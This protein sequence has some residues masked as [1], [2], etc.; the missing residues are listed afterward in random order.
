M[1]IW[2]VAVFVALLVPSLPVRGQS[3]SVRGKMEKPD[4]YDF[5]Y[6]KT[7]TKKYRHSEATPRLI[8][9][10]DFFC[11]QC[12]KEGRISYKT[13][14]EMVDILEVDKTYPNPLEG[15]TK[16]H[17]GEF[18]MLERPGH[19][20]L[21]RFMNDM[22]LKDPVFIEDPF[23]RIFVDLGSF[24]SKMPPYARREFELSQ[25]A[26][27]FPRVTSKTIS[28]TPHQRA[29]LY[30]FRAHRLLAEFQHLVGYDPKAPYMVYAPPF[31]GMR[32][33]WEVYIFRKQKDASAF[34][35]GFLG[36]KVN[37][38]LC[39]HLLTE[40]AMLTILHGERRRDVDVNNTF[41]HRL[42]YNF[43]TGYRGYAYDL[44]AW[45]A[46]GYAHL[47]ERRER[48]DFNTIIFGEG[49]IPKFRLPSKWKVGV[50][51]A[52]LAKKAPPFQEFAA[53]ESVGRIP[54]KMHPQIWSLVS[55]LVQLDQK[56]MGRLINILKEKK[57]GE[58][59]RNLLRRALAASYGLT[60]AQVDE[61][62]REW[63]KTTYPSI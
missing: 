21:R 33:K 25:L 8:L 61:G 36:Q 45:L 63:V 62:W 40:R 22:K 32:Q 31:M 3:G 19:L 43:I 46:L 15:K 12:A 47:M 49:R 29:H 55:Y 5:G 39:W 10:P 48:T 57:K 44:P 11:S 56:K 18:R 23:F 7:W 13:R 50:K 24:H 1:R 9:N 37:D 6:P 26:D 30:H 4:V 53:Y 52:V 54:P 17:F 34:V 20:V 42:C 2:I 60:L 28:I 35:E 41:T 59:T 38:G 14:E 27:I 51:K 16:E 58:S